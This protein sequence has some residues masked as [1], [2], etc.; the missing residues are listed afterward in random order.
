M[1]ISD[2]RDRP[3]RNSYWIK[4]GCFA[5]GEYP[6]HWDP[7]RAPE[8]VRKLLAAGIDHFIDLTE[9]GELEPY[10]GIVAKEARRLGLDI[11]WERHPIVDLSIPSSPEQMVRILDAVD[12]AL[13]DGKTLYVHCWGGVGRTGTT[14]GCWLVRHGQTGRRSPPPDRRVVAG[15]GKNLLS[16][17]IARNPGTE[18]VRPVVAE[19][20]AGFR[21]PR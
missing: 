6:G 17:Q 18:R 8:K 7:V 2:N 11:G 3:M 12:A 5:A 14:V 9:S 10:A 1:A 13:G 21:G 16:P 19:P 15:N 4:P 20:T